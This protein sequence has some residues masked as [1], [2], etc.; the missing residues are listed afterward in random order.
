MNDKLY[1]INSSM[2]TVTC[3]IIRVCYLGENRNFLIVA[4]DEKQKDK[5]NQFFY[6]W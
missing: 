2:W 4:V 3:E 5:E 6:L 1:K